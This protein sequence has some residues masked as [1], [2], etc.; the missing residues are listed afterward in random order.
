MDAVIPWS[1][2]LASI[3]PRRGRQPLGLEKMLRITSCS[4]GSISPIR[5][6]SAGHRLQRTGTRASGT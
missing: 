4:S 3:E 5:V 1:Q 6:E 2:L